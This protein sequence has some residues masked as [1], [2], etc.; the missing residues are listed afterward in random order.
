LALRAAAQ[1]V[2]EAGLDGSVGD[3]GNREP[4]RLVADRLADRNGRLAHLTYEGSNVGDR[5][6]D[7]YAELLGRE[8]E[9]LRMLTVVPSEA[10]VPWVL[11]PLLRIQQAEAEKLCLRLYEAHFL[12]STAPVGTEPT[13]YEVHPLVR[14]FAT[15]EATTGEPRTLDDARR[16]L[17]LGYRGTARAVLE[18]SGERTRSGP[19]VEQAETE[20]LSDGETLDR[21]AR[22]P[23]A[24]IRMEQAS[25]AHAALSAQEAG[26]HEL[27]WRIASRL[28]ECV[29]RGGG[30]PLV[31]AAI[32]AGL[33]AAGELGDETAALRLGC[34]EGALLSALE[35]YEEALGRLRQ[36][37]EEA[38]RRGMPELAA[39]ALRLRAHAHIQMGAFGS[40][41]PDL[42]SAEGRAV[43]AG[44]YG[45]R[46]RE[47]VRQLR[48]VCEGR[49]EPSR[50]G[51]DLPNDGSAEL[52]DWRSYHGALIG[53]E[54]A[55]RRGRWDTAGEL[56]EDARATFAGDL[57]R[58]AA[59]EYQ[60]ARLFLT[61]HRG[62]S[63]NGGHAETAVAY[64]ARAVMTFG[65]IQ[66][67]CGAARAKS[68]L[69]RALLA[70]GRPDWSE[71]ILAE[72]RTDAE[73]SR[74]TAG[75]GHGLVHARLLR[76]EGELL[77]ARVGGVPVRRR[78]A[79]RPDQIAREH[80]TRAIGSLQKA[81]RIFDEHCDWWSGAET[82]TMLG[83]AY[84][85]EG[86]PTKAFACLAG[87]LDQFHTAEDALGR[88]ATVNELGL[89]G[90]Q[91]SVAAWMAAIGRSHR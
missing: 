73:A 43:Q 49:R 31:R 25:L 46:E 30:G 55:R 53:A 32:A 19:G 71:G 74:A 76:A 51:A 8:R 3:A 14:I 39:R 59:I 58:A 5:L 75:P 15:Q 35:L 88:A 12:E 29:P 13:R 47:R 6:A 9:A 60:T 28:G 16:R 82:K 77:L 81:A 70:A 45:Y 27:A 66:T 18:L 87:A 91:F 2:S 21:I 44:D 34:A 33:A 80:L 4:W 86:Q 22:R 10:F 56:L 17:I 50:W 36:V 61:W 67:R 89:L 11:R 42:D 90:R 24:W 23:D 65:D 72:A 83:R 57:R 69:A 64:A 26:E 78:T 41:M 79:T 84:R 20:F 38:T 1:I 7:G 40:A 68:L 54:N 52:D 48:H 37:S 63:R 85:L 62:S